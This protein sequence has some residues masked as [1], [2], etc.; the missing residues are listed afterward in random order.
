M[1]HAFHLLPNGKRR[2]LT[3]PDIADPGSPSERASVTSSQED[4]AFYVDWEDLT[5]FN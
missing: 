5:V 2:R 3:L 4:A 1:S